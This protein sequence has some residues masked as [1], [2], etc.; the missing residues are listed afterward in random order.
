M[1]I[2]PNDG[3]YIT[4]KR[5]KWKFAHFDSYAN[6]FNFEREDEP[7]HIKKSLKKFFIKDQPLVLEIAAGNAQFSLELARRHPELNFIAIDIKSD[8]LYTSAK[9]ALQEEIDNIAFLRMPLTELGRVFARRSVDLIWLTFPDPFPRERSAKRRLTHPRFLAEYRK[10]LK[11]GGLLK[12][13][14]D[15]RELFLW[16]LEQLVQEKWQL[17]ELSFDLH[18]SNL[19]EEYKI[20]TYYEEG[21]TAQGIPTNIVTSRAD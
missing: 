14:T 2:L 16:S 20:K 8:R 18:D 15:N 21:F 13:K 5:K 11:P 9:K 7:T 3:L 12:Y 19:P 17:E 1:H 4:R 6:C 10:L